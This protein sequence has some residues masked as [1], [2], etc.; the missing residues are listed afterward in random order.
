M[1]RKIKISLCAGGGLLGTVPARAVL[2]VGKQSNGR[3]LSKAV[4][5][6]EDALPENLAP[7]TELAIVPLAQLKTIERV[8]SRNITDLE[9]DAF[10]TVKMQPWEIKEGFERINAIVKLF[11]EEEGAPLAPKP[12]AKEAAADALEGFARSLARDYDL[13]DAASVLMSLVGAIKGGYHHAFARYVIEAA[14]AARELKI[15][16]EDE[17]A[18]QTLRFAGFEVEKK[19]GAS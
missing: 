7:A 10:H 14:R 4:H 19:G 12:N 11:T 15:S 16:V 5:I 1:T 17:A 3:P 18:A 2:F 9:A 8:A 13:G 6:P